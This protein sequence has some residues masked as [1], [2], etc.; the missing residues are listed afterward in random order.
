MKKMSNSRKV[1]AGLGVG[2]AVATAVAGA[3]FL[4]GKQGVKTRRKVKSWMLKARAEVM[5]QIEQAKS[6]NQKNYNQAIQ[7]VA[8]KYR[9]LK[10]IDSREVDRLVGELKS[11]W[12]QI[13]KHV[14]KSTGSPAKKKTARKA[15]R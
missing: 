10:N 2:L 9:Q 12:R 7:A 8:Q 5:D 4:Y 1:A 3:Y 6:F 14:S 15:R 13:A 11:H